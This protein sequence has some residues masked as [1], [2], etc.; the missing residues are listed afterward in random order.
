MQVKNDVSKYEKRLWPT[1]DADMEVVSPSSVYRLLNE[2]ILQW[3]RILL[4]R[5]KQTAPKVDLN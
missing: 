4:L 1:L 2:E 3:I 5:A